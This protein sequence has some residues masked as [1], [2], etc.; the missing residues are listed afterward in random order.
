MHQ[1][2]KQQINKSELTDFNIQSRVAIMFFEFSRKPVLL[3]ILIFGTMV[4]I[5]S[6]LSQESLKVYSISVSSNVAARL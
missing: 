4:V 3:S 2:C 6:Y 1:T 5:S